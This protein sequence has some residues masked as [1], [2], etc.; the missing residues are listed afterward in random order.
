M[1]D[2]A[3]AADAFIAGRERGDLDTDRRTAPNR[4]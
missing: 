1:I 2:A 3:E 4:G